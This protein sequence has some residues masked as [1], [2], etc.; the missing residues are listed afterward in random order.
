MKAGFFQRLR[1][2]PGRMDFTL[3]SVTLV[4]LV[5]GCLFIYGAGRQTGGTFTHYWLRQMLAAFL[6]ACGFLVATA[7]DYRR[8]GKWAWLFHA[9]AIILLVLVLMAGRRINAARSWLPIFGFTLQPSEI[10]KPTTIL[11]SAYVLSRPAYTLKPWLK[12]LLLTIVVG[13][14]VALICMQPDWGT[15]LV[16]V[17]AVLV[18][19]F[20]AG[21]R[22]RW[23]ALGLPCAALAMFLLFPSLS[24][25]QQRRIETFLHPSQ[26]IAAFGWNAH[27]SLLA[28]GSGGFRG[29]GFMHGTQ[30]ILGFLPRKV[31]PT[32]FIFSVI[33]EETGFVG[34]AALLGAYAVLLFCCL[35]TAAVAGDDFGA[36]TAAGIG[37]LF[38]THVYINMGM[39]IGAA[40]IIGIPLPLVSYG[41]SFMLTCL[42]TLGLLQSVYGHRPRSRREAIAQASV[43]AIEWNR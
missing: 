8:V 16:F 28:V 29:K 33:S 20:L 39:T 2:L 7:I 35:R 41:G 14:P 25:R 9:G 43:T 15:A 22:W 21:L 31:A 42:L 18:M 10:A 11:L 36:Y 12:A 24:K 38:F 13:I 37:A 17:P 5:T 26:D 1:Q 30:Y 3:V 19:L 27:Q 34:A 40:P 4:L 32:D 23:I 6:G